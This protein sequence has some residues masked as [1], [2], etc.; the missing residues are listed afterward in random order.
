M[1]QSQPSLPGGTAASNVR[2][3]QPNQAAVSSSV[4]TSTSTAPAAMASRR[5]VAGRERVQV[6]DGLQRRR[7]GRLVQ[8]RA[9]A[10]ASRRRAGSRVTPGRGPPGQPGQ[11]ARDH[12]AVPGR[13]AGEDEPAARLEHPQHLAQRQLD[14]RDVVQHRVPDDQVERRRPS[15]GIVSASATRPSTSSPSDSA[16]RSA[17]STMPGLMSVTSPGCATPACMRLSRKKPVPAADL[18]RPRRTAS[19]PARRRRRT[20]RGRRSMQRSSYE[21]DHFSS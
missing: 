16:L 19:R 18:Q 9:A 2:T 1:A 11:P 6:D 14:V 5:S 10:G 20:A 15:Y 4:R 12:V 21:I 3:G 13:L 8:L 7:L 17:T